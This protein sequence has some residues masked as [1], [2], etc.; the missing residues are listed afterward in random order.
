VSA[1]LEVDS[2]SVRFSG[3][4]VVSEVSFSLDPGECVAI[5]GESGSGKSV[6]ARALLGLA[7][8]GSMTDARTLRFDGTDLLTA[9][10]RRLRAIRGPGIGLVSQGALVALD[11]LRPVG[12]E[13]ADAL[14]LHTALTPSE[15]QE[16]VMSLL[17]RCGVPEPALR[18][19]QR[20]DQ[21]SGGL[22]QRVVIASA[23][24]ADPR[25]IVADEPTTALDS[26]VQ[27]GILRLLGRLRDEGT[28]VLLISHDLAVVSTLATRIVVMRQGRIV[29]AGS[30]A[31]VLGS[32]R[33]PYTRSLVAAVPSGVPRGVRLV[34]REERAD[35]RP[36][37]GVRVDESPL[38][39][40]PERRET[41]ARRLSVPGARHDV[42]GDRPDD[43]S[44]R[45]TSGP[46]ADP[47][48]LLTATGLV[49]RFG[50]RV[51][52]AGVD[53][54]LRAGRT[55][56][57]VGESGSGK[58]TLARLVL[59]LDAPD[60]GDVRFLGD[61]WSPAPERARRSRRAL[62]GAVH[63]DPVS[64]FDPRLTVRRIL[65]DAATGGRTQRDEGEAEAALHRVGLSGDLLPRHPRSLSGGQ[66]QR[67]A[68]ARALAGHPR[69]VV[70]DEPVSSLDSAVQAQVLD[71]LDELQE[72]LGLAYLV[73]TH[74]LGVARHVGDEV[75]V[76]RHGSVVE[77]GTAESVFGAPSHPYTRSL[78]EA[79]P[80][81]PPRRG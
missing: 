56:A 33:H 52:V 79:A 71:L 53:L 42:V 46:G 61:A 41:D 32:P 30:T 37:A 1:L 74:D 81:L 72:S 75:L 68:I 31:E 44:D 78:V 16:R 36:G 57:V 51:A 40:V 47:E 6:T 19:A 60:E 29:E 45:P 12:R 76:M 39:A 35:D 23:I 58:T 8:E 7:G 66:Q 73:I 14:R 20:P 15:R 24:A 5:V 54:E 48:V 27:L 4:P 55:L 77:R 80:T 65:S 2:L 34:P 13:V 49:R 21:L 3:A 67:V 70:A 69:V 11:P 9:S 17:G 10:P 28:A 26:T 38:D 22:R 25:L 43:G 50:A 63:Q 59:G 18:A 62:L 64:S